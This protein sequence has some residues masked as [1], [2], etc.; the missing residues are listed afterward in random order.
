MKSMVFGALAGAGLILAAYCAFEYDND[1]VAQQI[2][3]HSR[4]NAGEQL[5]ALTTPVG[6]KSQLLTVID[7]RQRVIGVYHIDL[8]TGKIALRSVR[9]ITWDLQMTEF[10]GENPLPREIR[11]LLEQ[12]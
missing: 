11:M 1:A 12:R 4:V 7:Q 6:D 2:G 9:N 5:I 8:P 10:N 3:A